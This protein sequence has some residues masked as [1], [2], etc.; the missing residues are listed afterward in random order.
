MTTTRDLVTDRRDEY[1]FHDDIVYLAETKRGLTRDTVEEISRFKDEP[2]WMLQYRLRAYDHFMKRPLPTWGGDLSTIDFGNIVYYR[3]PSERE[4]RSWDDVPDQIKQT[5]ER[6]GIPEAERKFLAGVGAQYDSEVV[7]HSVRE[8]LSKIGVVFMGTD[9]ALKEYPEIFRKHFGTVVPAE[10]NKFSALNAAVWSGGSFVYVPPG[11]EVPLPLQAYFR[12]NGENTGQFERTL[13]V[14]DEG[15]K[16]HYIEGCTAPIYATESLHVAVV[17]VV[18]LPGSKVRYT[19]IQNWSNDVYNLVT[20]RAHA[21]AN[22]TVEWI[23]ANTGSRLTMKYPA[24]YLR[25]ENAT[26]DIISVAVAGKGQHQDTGAKAVHLAPN[27]RSRIVSKSVSKDGGRAT[28]RGNLK[29]APGATGV[30]ASVRCDALMLDDHSRSDTYPYIDIQEDDTTMSH[31]ATVG[32]VS[33]DQVFYLMSRG[34]TE[35]EATNLI[36]QGFLEVFTKELPMEYA[37]EFNRL[38][39]LEM[40]GSLG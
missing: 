33:A 32:K 34:L 7:Y 36:V 40:E 26:A 30:V 16:V 27:T 14:V 29:V 35:N 25:G 23:D 4:E 31:E 21:H 5:F 12:I 11:V 15:A 20:K 2:D 28:Y 22:S 37:I 38:V 8:E 18:A 10:D 9:Q 13:I 6:L 1:A 3:K 39:K 24:I 17:E 19:T